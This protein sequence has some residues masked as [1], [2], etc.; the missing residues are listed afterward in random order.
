MARLS[1]AKEAAA[2]VGPFLGNDECARQLV[3]IA[4]GRRLRERAATVTAWAA[5]LAL[6]AAAA[7]FGRTAKPVLVGLAAAALLRRAGSHG[8]RT[9]ARALRRGHHSFGYQRGY[10]P[11]PVTPSSASRLARTPAEPFRKCPPSYHTD[12]E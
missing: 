4:E 12:E 11:G 3:P 10:Q 2:P 1:A 7:G 8:A 9:A 6:L 5:L